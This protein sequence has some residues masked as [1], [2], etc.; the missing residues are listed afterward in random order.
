MS[1]TVVFHT[2]ESILI[3]LAK[4]FSYIL[5]D[6]RR[7]VT[8]ILLKFSWFF[9]TLAKKTQKC[10][11]QFRQQFSRAKINCSLWYWDITDK[12]HFFVWEMT[13][14][15]KFQSEKLDLRNAYDALHYL[16]S[17]R[18]LLNLLFPQEVI[19]TCLDTNSSFKLNQIRMKSH[20]N[21]ISHLSKGIFFEWVEYVSQAVSQ[22]NIFG[23]EIG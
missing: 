16:S 6:S 20:V 3:A 17:R 19:T 8:W 18:R 10:L 13:I 22:R 15:G 4:N 23:S 11:D 9:S 1:H 5:V 14:H 2:K 21:H 12:I 7:I